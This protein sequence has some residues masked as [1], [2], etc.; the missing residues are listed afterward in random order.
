MQ[1][2]PVTLA[3][4]E[5]SL[6]LPS[7]VSARPSSY[8]ALHGQRVGLCDRRGKLEHK[9]GVVQFAAV[10]RLDR[11][12]DQ[13][14]QRPGKSTNPHLPFDA[15]AVYRQDSPLHYKELQLYSHFNLA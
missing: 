9:A 11:L 13:L 5:R 2:N 8:D 1:A 12:I 6:G 3:S 15:T 10:G 7:S 4:H 14:H